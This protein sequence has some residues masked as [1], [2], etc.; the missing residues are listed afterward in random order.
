MLSSLTLVL[1][2]GIVTVAGLS[3]VVPLG[4]K[5]THTLISPPPGKSGQSFMG[6]IVMLAFAA[7]APV[8]ML[9]DALAI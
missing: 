7:S 5:S 4:P 8:G 1:S 6:L 9:T 3:N 2:Y